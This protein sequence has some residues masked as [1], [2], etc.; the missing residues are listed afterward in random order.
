VT[1]KP[2]NRWQLVL[3]ALLFLTPFAA[4]VLLRF[5][6]WQPPR[7]RNH[8]ELLAPPLPMHTIVAT[9]E[10]G[11]AWVFENVEREWSLLLRMP[12]R[13]G[14]PCVETLEVL[15]RVREA[16]GRHAGKLHVFEWVAGSHGDA[17]HGDA[18]AA[19]PHPRFAPLTLAGDL[20]EP[21]LQPAPAELPEL[22]LVDP[23]GYLV[24]HYPPEFDPSGL[25]KDL[26]RL[27][28]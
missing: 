7:T 19:P 4:A 23:H 12:A 10:D 8:G 6:D 24:M 20:P 3:I 11:S 1:P 16:Q 28:R 14:A 5:G 9:R 13:C 2:R 17:G 25:R 21:L 27:V 22:W 18:A 26:A 15:P